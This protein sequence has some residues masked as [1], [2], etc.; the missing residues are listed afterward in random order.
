MVGCDTVRLSVRG[1]TTKLIYNKAHQSENRSLGIRGF[2]RTCK[3]VSPFERMVNG[4]VGGKGLPVTHCENDNNNVYVGATLF[5][6]PFVVI[7]TWKATR[8][9][10]LMS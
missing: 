1:R 9:G 2:I 6:E 10:F 5:A 3:R 4:M 7:A 8:R